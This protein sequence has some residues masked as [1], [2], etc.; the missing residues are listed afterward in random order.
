MT[1]HDQFVKE[2]HAALRLPKH[3]RAFEIRCA[4]DE[5]VVVRCEYYPEGVDGQIGAHALLSEYQLVQQRV[6]ACA[7]STVNV[8]LRRR[9][10]PVRFWNSYR[11]WRRY[12]GIGPALRAAWQVAR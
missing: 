4:V 5:V 1:T 2:L 9:S 10:F 6:G 12:L 11:E 3:A 8:A 7:D